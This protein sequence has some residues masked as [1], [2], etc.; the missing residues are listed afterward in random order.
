MNGG[1]SDLVY[2]EE[3]VMVLKFGFETPQAT[4]ALWFSY[5]RGPFAI[6]LSALTAT[7]YNV[8]SL[9]A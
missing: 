4:M 6:S 5:L 8:P 2:E 9:R 3:R 1:L 7:I